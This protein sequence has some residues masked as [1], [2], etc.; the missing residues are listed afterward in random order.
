MSEST[1]NESPLPLCDC[2]SHVA[3]RVTM[4]DI[5]EATEETW[6]GDYDV[7]E[8]CGLRVSSAKRRF[9]PGHDAKLK[10]VLQKAYRNGDD[11]AWVEGGMVIHSSATN[12]AAKLDWSH[13]LTEAPKRKSR[14]KAKK[15]AEVTLPQAEEVQ[16]FRP[17][18]VKVGRWWKDGVIVLQDETGVTVEYQT[19]KGS[20]RVALPLDSD[21][22]EI[23]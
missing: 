17:A 20:E 14:A 16:G 18:R 12:E 4:A 3:Y 21:K 15:E 5:P 23:G 6:G 7:Y 13:F 19:R 10:S 1:T 11:F 9:R 8:S 2:R 22:L